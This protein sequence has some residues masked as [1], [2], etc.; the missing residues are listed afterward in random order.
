MICV[1]LSKTQAKHTP[2]LYI[3]FVCHFPLTIVAH[4]VMYVMREQSAERS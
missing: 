2:M 3:F 1:C 4:R